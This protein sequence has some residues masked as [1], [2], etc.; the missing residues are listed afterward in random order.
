M[1]EAA[2]VVFALAL[3]VLALVHEAIR[4]SVNDKLPAPQR[5]SIFNQ[6][7]NTWWGRG[8]LLDMHMQLYPESK[9]RLAF[10]IDL[11]VVVAAFVLGCVAQASLRSK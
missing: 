11:V 3:P 9:L 2:F 8:G 1:S 7:G 10:W 5:F 6:P 4:A